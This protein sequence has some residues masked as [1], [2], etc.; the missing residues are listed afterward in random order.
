M[1]DILD[2]CEF[3]DSYFVLQEEEEGVYQLHQTNEEN[4]RT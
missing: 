1:F 2:P 3:G 4:K